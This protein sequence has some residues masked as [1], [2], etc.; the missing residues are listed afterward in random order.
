MIALRIEYLT[1][2]SVAT[3][4][5]DRR[6]AEWPPHPARVFS[7]LVDAWADELDP[8][9]RSAL[10]WLCSLPPPGLVVP[11][12][13]GRAVM[14][15]YVPLNDASVVTPSAAATERL[16]EAERDV[17]LADGKAKVKAEAALSRT[18][19][20]YVNSV[21][22][23]TAAPSKITP[24]AAS[25]GARVL[26]EGRSKQARAFPSVTPEAPVVWLRW[27][28]EAQ[29]DTL[30]ALSRI[31]ARVHR[32]GHSSSL[33]VLSW[34]D[35]APDA[36]V[37]PDEGGD[38]PL[39]VAGPGQVERLVSAF[40]GDTGHHGEEPRILPFL[41]VR[42][43]APR[44]V[45]SPAPR[46]PHQRWVVLERVDGAPLPA[47]RGVEL[48][49]AVR[50]G[51]MRHAE[52]PVH[53][54]ISGHEPDG[55]PT[56]SP[57]VSVVPLPFVGRVHADGLIRGIALLFPEM[58]DVSGQR[59]AERA[60]AR[61]EAAARAERLN[62]HEDGAVLELGLGGRRPGASLQVRRVVWGEPR[63][64]SL[65]LESWAGK[66]PRRSWV[67]VTPVALDRNPGD[68]RSPIATVRAKA[69]QEASEAVQRA[70]SRLGL[71]LPEVLWTATS[72]GPGVF[73]VK[74]FP[75]Y[76]QDSNK[77]RRVRVHV[78]LRFPEPVWGPIVL[79]AG[80]H[81][82]LGLMRP[83]EDDDVLG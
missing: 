27:D 80:R 37:V 4:Y 69:E 34:T 52:Q 26:P 79:G 81:Q 36:N 22:S 7:A 54:Y 19:I 6:K 9:E 57:H 14:T 16:R 33:V 29:A 39:R 73:P 70:C 67:S 82:G 41:S 17:Q 62:G 35:A 59:A 74:D 1:G 60:L 63:L 38:M 25:E 21:R 76:P 12:Y 18:R 10:S 68:L 11:G 2:R 75:A 44:R 61:W 32:L 42:Y 8:V 47:T 55:T 28:A 65:R 78:R 58:A 83:V 64:E 23:A 51:L 56:R 45:V 24:A 77:V 71:P 72:T 53:P 3:A 5:D 30:A 66:T 31:A 46:P 20:A 50:S 40:E 49:R 13:S 15:H 48:A 43:G